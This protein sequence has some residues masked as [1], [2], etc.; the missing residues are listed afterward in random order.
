MAMK[1]TLL[2]RLR[3]ELI[4]KPG[5]PGPR[6]LP[7]W[8]ACGEVPK[9]MAKVDSGCGD[10]SSPLVGLRE[11][12]LS[13]RRTRAVPGRGGWLWHVF[14]AESSLLPFLHSLAVL[15]WECSSLYL[16]PVHPELIK[17]LEQ[18]RF[19]PDRT[20]SVSCPVHRGLGEWLGDSKHLLQILQLCRG[21]CGHR[22][23]RWPGR[24]EHHTG[25]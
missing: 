20:F 19:N 25:G 15:Q 3:N 16:H 12:M 23:A 7:R 9:R 8:G 1:L 2:L 4:S 24:G 18:A 6:C 14:V 11:W 22:A 10:Q 17:A 5:P 13:K 21:E